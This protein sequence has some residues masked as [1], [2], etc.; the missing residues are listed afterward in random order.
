MYLTD[1]Y[2]LEEDSLLCLH[3]GIYTLLDRHTSERAKGAKGPKG[4]SAE[5]D[6]WTLEMV[7]SK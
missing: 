1:C 6:Q 4:Q 5:L 3:S 2:M 7:P